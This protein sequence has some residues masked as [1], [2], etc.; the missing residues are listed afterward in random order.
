MIFTFS[1]CQKLILALPIIRSTHLNFLFSMLLLVVTG[2]VLLMPTLHFL[3]GCLLITSG[4][5]S[6]VSTRL[7]EVRVWP[8]F[9]LTQIFF[10]CSGLTLFKTPNFSHAINLL[11][12]LCF[13]FLFLYNFKKT[14]RY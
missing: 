7:A 11:I 4:C 13:L 12:H 6:K 9:Q 3:K 2:L 8:L 5:F 10:L 1:H 14:S